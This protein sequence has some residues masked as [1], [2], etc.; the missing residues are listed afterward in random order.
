MIFGQYVQLCFSGRQK[1]RCAFTPSAVLQ[2]IRVRVAPE[3]FC[4]RQKRELVLRAQW[5]SPTGWVWSEKQNIVILNAVKDLYTDIM[6]NLWLYTANRAKILR[7]WLRMTQYQSVLATAWVGDGL[8]DIP[9][10]GRFVNSSC[11]IRFI[12]TGFWTAKGTVRRQPLFMEL[13]IW[14]IN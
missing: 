14:I 6:H 4:R 5:P 13:I 11:G 1:Q 3:W 8:P 12:F 10:G 9:L 2:D 7:L